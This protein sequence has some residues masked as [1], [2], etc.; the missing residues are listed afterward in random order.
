M[1]LVRA[2][3]SKN[4]PENKTRKVA[5]IFEEERAQLR[6]VGR[7]FDGYVERAVRV[8]G[9]CLVQYDTNRYSV[10]KRNPRGVK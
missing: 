2:S 9:T 8:S 6:P 5:D 7:P 3:G 10:L 4:H 1:R